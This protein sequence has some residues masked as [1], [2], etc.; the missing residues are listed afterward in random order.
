MTGFAKVSPRTRLTIGRSF[1]PRRQRDADDCA[2]G[3]VYQRLKQ[4]DAFVDDTA[5]VFL[6]M[7]LSAPSAIIIRSRNG[8]G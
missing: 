2:G 6:G 7:R 5:Q 4:T 1:D 3:P 8:V